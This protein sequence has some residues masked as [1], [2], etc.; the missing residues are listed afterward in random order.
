MSSS[1][2]RATSW[3]AA[4]NAIN[5][6][7]DLSESDTAIIHNLKSINVDP[8]PKTGI[9]RTSGNET[10][11]PQYIKDSSVAWLASALAH[12][13]YHVAQYLRGE[14]YRGQASEVP[15]NDFQAR[16]GAKFG[17]TQDDLNHLKKDTHQANDGTSY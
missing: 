6:A 2:R 4:A 1:S 11:R 17:L 14:P 5:G 8:V 12:D 9:D 15:A 13:A 3:F 16:V 7:K 10:M